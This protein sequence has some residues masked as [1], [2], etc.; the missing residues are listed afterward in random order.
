MT[1]ARLRIDLGPLRQHDDFR[2]LFTANLV[3]GIGSG[4]TYVALPFQ[5]AEL[6]DSYLHTS[7]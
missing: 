7:G 5:V 3:T 4:A 2:R 1:S 6:T